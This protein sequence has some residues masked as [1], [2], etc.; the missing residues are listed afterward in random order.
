V[1]AKMKNKIKEELIRIAMH[2]AQLAANESNFPFGAVVADVEG[3]I[4]DSA[5]NTL[6]TDHDPTAHAEIN[7]IRRL[8]KVYEPQEFA[9]IYLASNAESC[10]MCFSA[11]IK[12]GIVH[13]IFGAPSEPHME[14]FLTV[15]EVAKFCRV[16]L[17][18][19]YGI[20]EQECIRQIAEARS[21]Q[22]RL[23]Q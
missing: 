1:N 6:E 13:Y 7:L 5:H 10:S 11:A 22:R 4:I 9:Q 15:K 19:S 23:A 2:E 14:P 17:D 8:A 18:I 16:R 12:A 3:N 20:L 21:N